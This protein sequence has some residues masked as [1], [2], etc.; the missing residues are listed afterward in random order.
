MQIEVVAVFMLLSN[1][2][3]PYIVYFCVP[4]SSSP[5]YVFDSKSFKSTPI[6]SFKSFQ[7]TPIEF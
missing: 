5:V 7:S 6:E 1:F 2:C 4:E 3:S